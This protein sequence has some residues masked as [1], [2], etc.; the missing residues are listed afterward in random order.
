MNNNTLLHSSHKKTY[1]TKDF[2]CDKQ[3]CDKQVYVQKEIKSRYYISLFM[4][5]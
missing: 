3:A 2:L 5:I 1:T 4:Y